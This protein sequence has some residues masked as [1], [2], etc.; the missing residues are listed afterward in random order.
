MTSARRA[1]KAA[2]RVAPPA[3]SGSGV[4]PELRDSSHEV[5]H[6]QR[7][8]RAWM[9][10]HRWS[11]PPSERVGVPTSPANRRRAAAAA[12]TVDTGVLVITYGDGNHLHPDWH[13]L[14][15]ASLID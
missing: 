2:S 5:W 6:D 1:A 15:A 3:V 13:A 7:R 12:W 9:A 8:Y 4:P 11:L 10:G 14:R